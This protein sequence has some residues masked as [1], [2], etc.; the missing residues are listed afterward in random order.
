MGLIHTSDYNVADGCNIVYSEEA[1]VPG[2]S[3]NQNGQSNSAE[4]Q[5]YN[6]HI[7]TVGELALSEPVDPSI[8]VLSCHIKRQC[9]I[10]IRSYCIFISIA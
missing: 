5:G 10:F 6:V 9:K 4:H 3:T 7:W 8:G 2:C 1:T